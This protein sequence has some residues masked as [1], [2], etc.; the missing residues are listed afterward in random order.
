MT[1]AEAEVIDLTGL[2]DSSSESEHEQGDNNAQDEDSGS[3]GSSDVSEIELHLDEV[4]R[5]QLHAA[6]ATVSEARLRHVLKNLIDTDQAVE[7]AL[8][9]EFVTV[10]RETRAV[11]PRWE[12]CMN[13]DAEYDVNAAQEDDE[14]SFHPGESFAHLLYEWSVVC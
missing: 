6:I 4:S 2:S 7:I 14:C 12:R 11:V 10:K 1:T 3:E 13:C 9:R 5:S 8:T